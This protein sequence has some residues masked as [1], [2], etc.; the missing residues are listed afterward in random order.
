MRPEPA[1]KA[2]ARGRRLAKRPPDVQQAGALFPGHLT[3][4]QKPKSRRN[5]AAF[6]AF[7]WIDGWRG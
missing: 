6:V 7:R 5:P 4:T 1:R 3:G 2:F